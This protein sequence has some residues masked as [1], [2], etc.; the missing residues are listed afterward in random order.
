MNKVRIDNWRKAP[1]WLLHCAER[2]EDESFELTVMIVPLVL[3]MLLIAFVT[4]VRS[5]QMPAW[6]AA[7]E[8][9]RAAIA[10]LNEG[11]GRAQGMRAAMGSLIGNNISTDA[12]NVVINGSWTPNGTASCQVSYD[13]DVSDIAGI[14]VISGGKIPISAL[15]TMRVEPYKSRWSP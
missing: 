7:S 5:S 3:M 1:R 8:C 12:V 10:T 2:G 9:A 15:V 6:T 4:A 13:I 11:I 14:S